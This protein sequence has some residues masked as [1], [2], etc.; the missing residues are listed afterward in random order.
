MELPDKCRIIVHLF[1]YEDY[2]ITEIAKLLDLSEGAVKS[3][4]NR[5]RKQLRMQLTEGWENE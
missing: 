3:R 5:A 1:Y 4:L 2:S